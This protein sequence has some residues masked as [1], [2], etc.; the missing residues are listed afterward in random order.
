MSLQE[1]RPCGL[2]LDVLTA[3]SS[4]LKRAYRSSVQCTELTYLSDH[5]NPYSRAPFILA[6]LCSAVSAPSHRPRPVLHRPGDGRLQGLLEG[7]HRF[8]QHRPVLVGEGGEE[9]KAISTRT[10]TG[11]WGPGGIRPGSPG[12]ADNRGQPLIIRPFP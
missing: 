3:Q 8:D 4:P 12:G 6:S 10:F 1:W 5:I 11:P 2:V 7:V 9:G